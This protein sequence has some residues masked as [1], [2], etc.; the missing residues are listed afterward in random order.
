[1]IKK[2]I[3]AAARPE[4]FII[5]D[6]CLKATSPDEIE[7]TIKDMDELGIN[8]LPYNM[9]DIQVNFVVFMDIIENNIFDIDKDDRLGLNDDC[10]KREIRF[11]FCDD[12]IESISMFRLGKHVVTLS[13]FNELIVDVYKAVSRTEITDFER[14]KEC[15]DLIKDAGYKCKDILVV[16]LATRNVVK[17]RNENKALR[18]G[19]GLSNE[20]K[21]LYMTSLSVPSVDRMVS[22]MEHPPREGRTPRAHLRRGHIRMQPYGPRNSLRRQTWIQPMFVNADEQFVSARRGYNVSGPLVE[23][24]LYRPSFGNDGSIVSY[25]VNSE[26]SDEN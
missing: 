6:D 14:A 5:H 26:L 18:L 7:A 16:L 23:K 13:T 9:I 8:K 25:I 10:K 21:A 19:I 1:M 15:A 11:R 20:F 4:L 22:D 17:K 24:P 2:P 12:Q 3:P